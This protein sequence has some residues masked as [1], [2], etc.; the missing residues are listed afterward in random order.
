MDGDAVAQRPPLHPRPTSEATMV[1]AA[2]NPQPP[3]SE[4][5]QTE[6][7]QRHPTTL[8]K[9]KEPVMKWLDKYKRP[10]FYISRITGTIILLLAPWIFY[11]VVLDKGQLALHRKVAEQVANHPRTTTH[12]VVTISA[13]IGRAHV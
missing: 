7:P 13:K 3:Q 9:I 4:S 10:V 1:A 8:D 6:K 11:H 2:P 12:F 5:T